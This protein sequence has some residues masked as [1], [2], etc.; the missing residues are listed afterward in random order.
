[1][2]IYIPKTRQTKTT[3]EKQVRSG[4]V[5]FDSE[6]EKVQF[7]GTL[8]HD[9]ASETYQEFQAQFTVRNVRENK[10]I[11]EISMNLAEHINVKNF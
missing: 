2:S 1:M 4:V 5:T 7:T 10:T 3:Q 11:G 9:K 6:Q 8:V